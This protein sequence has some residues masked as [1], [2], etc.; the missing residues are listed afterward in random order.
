MKT[1]SEWS[2]TD[3]LL[4]PK[5]VIHGFN[6][7]RFDNMLGRILTILEVMPM[8]AQQEGAI[9]SLIKQTVWDTWERP[10]SIEEK[11]KNFS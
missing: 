3:D 2:T 1:T 11:E 7:E 6:V 10:W 4:N 8:E 5:V 9:K